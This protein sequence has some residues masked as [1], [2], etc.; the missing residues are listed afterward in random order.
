MVA[1]ALLVILTLSVHQLLLR[2]FVASL[3]PWFEAPWGLWVLLLIGLW[4]FS[5]PRRSP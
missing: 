5:G 1:A 3:Q 2:P 4:L